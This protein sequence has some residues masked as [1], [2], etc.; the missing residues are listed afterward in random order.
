MFA[1]KKFIL[2]FC[3]RGFIFA[4]VGRYLIKAQVESLLWT[5]VP[6]LVREWCVL[7]SCVVSTIECITTSDSSCKNAVLLG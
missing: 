1:G 5:G 3:H 7:K 2:N 4:A 6:W